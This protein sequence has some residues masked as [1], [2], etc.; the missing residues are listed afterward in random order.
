MPSAV[1][2][3]VFSFADWGR[4]QNALGRFG[5][6]NQRRWQADAGATRVLCELGRAATLT[7]QSS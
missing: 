1:S 5:A 4:R 7:Q 6:S 2:S 3:S